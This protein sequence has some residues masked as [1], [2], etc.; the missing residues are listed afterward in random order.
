MA[1]VRTENPLTTDELPLVFNNG[2]LA[3]LQKAV[4]R[5]G[6]KDEE[7]LL[8]YALAVISMSATRTLTII[9]QDGKSIAL[10]PSESLLL[11]VADKEPEDA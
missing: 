6:F 9:D 5:L 7:S 8:R 10:N 2:D 4:N 1:I 11:Q 3:A